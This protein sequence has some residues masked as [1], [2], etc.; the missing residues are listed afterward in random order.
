MPCLHGATC[1]NTGLDSYKCGC[2]P[3]YTGANCQT[4]IDEC[5]PDPCQNGANCIVSLQWYG[6]I[7]TVTRL[8]DVVINV[9][10]VYGNYII[11]FYIVERVDYTVIT[12]VTY[13]VQ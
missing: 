2:V 12:T 10:L 6:V 9:Q 4:E 5:D 11:I 3:G 1:T 7:I 13:L 8:D